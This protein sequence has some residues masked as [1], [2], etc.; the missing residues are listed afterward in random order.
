MAPKPSIPPG[1]ALQEHYNGF[2]C[3]IINCYESSGRYTTRNSEE[4]ARKEAESRENAVNSLL[5]QILDQQALVRLSN[6]SAVKPDKAKL[7]E[8]AVINMARR[9]QLVGKLSD[10]GLKQLME[11]VSQQTTR[12]TTVKFDRRRNN[13]DSDG[14]DDY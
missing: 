11:H 6:L 3:S 5:S 4:Q 7:V 2:H 10:E 12:T 1:S 14:D 9:G 13:L 8:S